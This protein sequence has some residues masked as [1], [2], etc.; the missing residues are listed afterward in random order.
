M[1]YSFIEQHRHQY[2]VGLQCRVLN[3]SVSGYYA[4]RGRPQSR[5]EQQNRQ[6]E[7]W[8]RAVFEQHRHRYGSPRIQRELRDQGII[9]SRKRVARLMGKAGLR[10]RPKRRFKR[11][12]D[13]NHRYPVAP[14]HL[15]RCFSTEQVGGLNQVW[16]GDITYLATTQ[17]WL[18]LA[19][20]LDLHSRR[21]VGW[22][23]ENTLQQN[24][25]QQALERAL[26]LRHP[27]VGLLH[28]SDRG[29]QYAATDYRALLAD[30]DILCSMSRRGDCWDNAPVESFFATL[31]TELVNEF[32][33]CF[34]S[35]QQARQEVGHYIESYYNQRRRHSALG[36]LSPVDFEKQQSL[37]SGA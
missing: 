27:P 16:A 22:A 10:A 30:Q 32:N 5:H 4:W 12:T 29:S 14:N 31:K 18:Y 24:L 8:I 17:G 28:H 20:L 37:T 33:G 23:M 15:A 6:L 26:A 36:Y 2:A 21:V 19:V 11:T 9:C 7:V 1:R 3:V 35:R 13:S 34:Q 25:T